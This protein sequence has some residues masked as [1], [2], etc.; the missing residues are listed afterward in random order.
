MSA[1]CWRCG[2]ADVVEIHVQG[3]VTII[4]QGR[5][6]GAHNAR[7]ALFQRQCSAC[8][9]CQHIRPAAARPSLVPTAA[10]CGVVGGIGAIRPL[11]TVSR[12]AEDN[13]GQ[14]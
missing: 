2:S 3:T 14:R 8:G 5:T 12:S 10:E 9:Q 11:R 13:G 4:M 7:P 6:M 1:I